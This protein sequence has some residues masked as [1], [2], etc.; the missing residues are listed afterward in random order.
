MEVIKWANENVINFLGGAQKRK[1]YKKYR[2][3]K[4]I[5]RVNYDE[6]NVILYNTMTGCMITLREVELSYADTDKYCTYSSFLYEQYFIVPEDFNEEEV[7]EDYRN[8]NNAYISANYL[9]RITN[10]TILTT[11]RCN[12]RCKYCYELGMKHKQHMTP[13]MADKVADFIMDHTYEGEDILLDW[14]GGEPLFNKDIIEIITARMSGAN[15]P[16]RSSIVSNG[17]L[18]SR[19]LAQHA[20]K[21]WNLQ[22][23][24]I[25]LDGTE[26]VYN[27]IKNFI[28]KDESAFAKVIENIRILCSEGITVVVR[29]NIDK[30]NANDILQLIPF[31]LTEFANYIPNGTFSI[32][33]WPIFEI[34][35]ERTQEEIDSLMDIMMNITAMLSDGGISPALN[36][37]GI[38][39]VHCMADNGKSIVIAPDGKLSVCEHHFN[40][41]P[42][43]HIDN[44]ETK[45]IEELKKWR[46][47]MEYQK[48]CSDCPLKP[49]CY[50]LPNCP[51]YRI[52]R[53]KEKDYQIDSLTNAVINEYLKY[54][55]NQN[56]CDNGCC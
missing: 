9:D 11:T 39:N 1:M 29:I 17:Y 38:K 24:Q 18:F 55:Y 13:E 19:E 35:F 33:C 25:T 48:I 44:P 7:I 20:K 50:K 12:A 14:F 15:R 31:L 16:F 10:Y 22:N 46:V 21:Y 23:V 49:M 54:R 3:N 52:C 53:G 30:N 27:E 32:Y 45:D 34:G 26:N 37:Y 42:I 47:K 43:G 40:D 51:S 8:R 41:M 6:D 4:F 5:L 56:N 28:Y 36:E 2:F